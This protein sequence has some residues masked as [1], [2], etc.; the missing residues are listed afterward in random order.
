M[1][2]LLRIWKYNQLSDKS[3]NDDIEKKKNDNE[4][5]N[6]QLTNQLENKEDFI[7]NEVNIINSLERIS[8]ERYKN[9]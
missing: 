6:N 7:D 5:Y 8:E 2:L 3:N 1:C 4:I 9:K